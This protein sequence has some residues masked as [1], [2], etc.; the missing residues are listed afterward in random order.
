ML[1][2]TPK[3]ASSPLNNVSEIHQCFQCIPWVFLLL[4]NIPLY[5]NKFFYPFFLDEQIVS[6][7]QICA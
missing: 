5:G 4:S 1:R 2:V 3:E 7:A 6:S